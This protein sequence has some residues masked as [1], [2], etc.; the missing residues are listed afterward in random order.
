M[1]SPLFL[2]KRRRTSCSCRQAG[3]LAPGSAATRCARVPPS[4]VRAPS[5]F[6]NALP[7]YSGGTAPEFDRLPSRPFI[8]ATTAARRAVVRARLR[9]SAKVV[10]PCDEARAL[11]ASSK[12]ASITGLRQ[13]ALTGQ[14]RRQ[15]AVERI[16]DGPEDLALRDGHHAVGRDRRDARAAD[17]T[18]A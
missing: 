14:Q 11:A 17:L 13:R 5:G 10:K 18:A 15:G 8:W 2:S 4:P 6:W 12:C 3:L 1:M 7:G 16:G 9:P